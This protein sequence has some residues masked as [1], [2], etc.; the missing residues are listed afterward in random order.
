M[1]KIIICKFICLSSATVVEIR[2]IIN[3]LLG[4]EPRSPR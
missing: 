3:P 1:L 2:K 4:I